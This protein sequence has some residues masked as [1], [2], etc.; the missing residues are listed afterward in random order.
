[1]SAGAQS[2]RPAEALCALS[3]TEAAARI[4]AGEIESEALVRACLERIAQR[5]SAV[6]AWAQVDADGAL[7]AAREADRQRHGKAHPLGPLHGVPIGTQGHHRRRGPQDGVQLGNLS[8]SS[9]A[10]RRRC[11]RPVA[12]GRSDHSGQDGNGGIRRLGRAGSRPP[13][14]PTTCRERR[15]AP[16]PARRRQSPTV[17]FL[18]RWEPK[19]AAR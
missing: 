17:W 5:E 16:P 15:E 13:A 11:R 7:R 4:A 19:P 3:A 12:R 1:M 10:C 14:I 9:R 2:T 6:R 18:S 8:R